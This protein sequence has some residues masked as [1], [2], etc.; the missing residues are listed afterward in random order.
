MDQNINCL[1]YAL[2]RQ[3]ANTSCHGWMNLE[4]AIY[5]MG[6]RGEPR[7]WQGQN[8]LTNKIWSMVSGV[9]RDEEHDEL[10]KSLRY[11][12]FKEEYTCVQSKSAGEG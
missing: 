2:E 9:L 1:K 4:K 10:I 5:V 7:D 6:K 11:D 3:L 12:Y 8:I